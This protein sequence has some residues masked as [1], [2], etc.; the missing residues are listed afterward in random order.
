MNA[1]GD[2]GQSADNGRE[3]TKTTGTEQQ[4]LHTHKIYWLDSNV[5]RHLSAVFALGGK[6]HPEHYKS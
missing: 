1:A 3:N 5:F 6:D 4:I 2:G